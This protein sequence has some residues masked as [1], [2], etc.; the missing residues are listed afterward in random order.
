MVQFSIIPLAL[1]TLYAD[2]K[3]MVK[4]TLSLVNF[5]Y[6]LYCEILIIIL[7]CMQILV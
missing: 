1:I 3:R 6:L 5:M 7:K 2:Q 4:C